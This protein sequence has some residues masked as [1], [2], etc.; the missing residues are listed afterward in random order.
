MNTR[1]VAQNC[2]QEI[3]TLSASSRRRGCEYRLDLQFL[4]TV[5]NRSLIVLMVTVLQFCRMDACC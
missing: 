3:L 4:Q 5:S 1:N 2:P